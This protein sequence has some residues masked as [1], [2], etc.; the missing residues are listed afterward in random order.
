VL[1]ADQFARGEPL[2][3]L[4]WF[5]SMSAGATIGVLI[6]ARHPRNAIG[7]L[8]FV[9]TGMV[10]PFTLAG[11]YG[12]MPLLRPA[13]DWPGAVWF[14]WPAGTLNQ[15]TAPTISKSA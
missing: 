6:V 13:L 10:S 14:V 2:V 9:A 7:W 11:E 15:G 5:V 12:V 1:N 8:V 3:M 4:A